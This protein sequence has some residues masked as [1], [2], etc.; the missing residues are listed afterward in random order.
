VSVCEEAALQRRPIALVLIAAC[1]GAG[2]ADLT[3]PIP[4][5]LAAPTFV[6]DILPA[7]QLSCGSR[8]STCHGGNAPTGHVAWSTDAP[9]V[10]RD[11]YEDL[12]SAPPANA[13]AQFPHRV[14]PG[15]P[16]H[17][18]LLEKITKDEPGGAGYGARMPYGLPDVCPSTV[19]TI[20]AWIE[21][22]APY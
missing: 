20:T 19:T 22:G 8:T 14:T 21:Q 16:A 7:L 5:P 2:T 6:R 18:W 11:V 1:S 9:R 10:P 12:T 3:C 15:D 17:S 4:A 13:P